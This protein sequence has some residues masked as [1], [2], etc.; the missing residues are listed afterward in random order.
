MIKKKLIRNEK[1]EA[2]IG[3]AVI[4]ALVALIA[5][6]AIPGVGHW[7]AKT[8]CEIPV[9]PG[10]AREYNEDTATC[11]QPNEPDCLGDQEPPC[12]GGLCM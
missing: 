8:L 12:P 10:H 2:L 7:A 3:Y 6:T 5:L 4:V 1:G 9:L 11:C